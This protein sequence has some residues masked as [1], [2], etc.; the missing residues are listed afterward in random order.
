M[1]VAG[2]DTS[3]GPVAQGLVSLPALPAVPAQLE[4]RWWEALAAAVARLDAVRYGGVSMRAV[5]TPGRE[6]RRALIV[7]VAAGREPQLRRWLATLTR[8]ETLIP[9]SAHLPINRDEY[10]AAAQDFPPLRCRAATSGFEAGGVWLACDF[11]LAPTLSA[12]M[13]EADAYGYRLGYAVNVRPLTVA[14]EQ[15]RRAHRNALA[16][17]DL[18]GAPPALAAMQRELAERLRGAN[19]IC[20]EYVAVDPGEAEDWLLGAL[21]RRFDGAFS[22]LRFETAEWELVY[23]GFEDEL[24]CP[25]F[26][27]SPERLEDDLCAAV[28]ADAE[29]ANLLVWRPPRGLTEPYAAPYRPQPDVERELALPAR[30]LPEPDRDDE[31][32]FFV[33]YRR[34]DLDRVVPMIEQVRMLGWRV[35]YDVEIAGGS[36][37][38]AVLEQRL[39]ACS[40]VLLFLS[41]AAVD[42]KFVRRE[43]Q[44]ADSLGKPII[45][46]QIEL[47]RLR[48]GLGL[49]LSQYQLLSHGTPD[50]ADR[51]QEA[52]ADVT[53][54]AR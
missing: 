30:G 13:E 44:F 33:S 31:P 27:D 23:D 39:A 47:A 34:T 2:F 9:G 51:L 5:L 26:S 53:P 8:L 19:A 20:E 38:N 40:G 36:E 16:V 49:L 48:Y 43:L 1:Y 17:Q 42:S 22:A 46:V 18:P 29:I 6:L 7:S 28:L 3:D 25:M 52:L 41:Q 10:D 4:G 37:W 21:R 50:F 32:F 24:A 12:L 45:G 35:W 54:A 14:I 11:R 15:I